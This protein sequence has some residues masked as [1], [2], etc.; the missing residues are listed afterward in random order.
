MK[1]VII[2]FS[3]FIS[4][5]PFLL[6]KDVFAETSIP[7][8]ECLNKLNQVTPPV[9]MSYKCTEYELTTRDIKDKDTGI[10]YKGQI[11]W[12][13]HSLSL[14]DIQ[15]SE[16]VA[17]IRDKIGLVL[18]A[19][20]GLLPT[21]SGISLPVILRWQKSADAV[22]Y[23]YQISEDRN[24][25]EFIWPVNE[26]QTSFPGA[27][28]RNSYYWR[29]R[30][31]PDPTGKSVCSSW[32]EATFTTTAEPSSPSTQPSPSTPSVSSCVGD[33]CTIKNP[34]GVDNFEDLLNK[35]IDFIFWVGMALAPVMFI[36]AGFMY[37]I[38]AG[39]PQKVEQAKKIIIYTVI[40]L[41]V[42]LLAR[43]LVK[44]LESIIGVK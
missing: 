1:K 2:I 31:C 24:W 11:G 8:L 23:E 12:Y 13:C 34:L 15:K 43:G 42:L 39:S 37:V 20:T 44:V 26:N 9:C 3:I 28:Y 32:A 7:A 41:V 14:T 4:F 30:A 21:G 22:K 40:G 10:V 36:V 5:L 19:P 6:I 38:S 33:A 25:S 35:I 27:G 29:V 18:S 16:V 17:Y